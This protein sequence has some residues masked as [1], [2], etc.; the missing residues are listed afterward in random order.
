MNKDT[1]WNAHAAKPVIVRLFRD[2][3]HLGAAHFETCGGITLTVEFDAD[4]NALIAY[5]A[6]G[7]EVWRVPNFIPD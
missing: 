7:R 1:T 3:F 4:E 6:S 5:D 2:L